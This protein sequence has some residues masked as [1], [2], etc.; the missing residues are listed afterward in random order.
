MNAQV[1]RQWSSDALTARMLLSSW[2]LPHSSISKITSVSDGISIIRP[3]PVNKSAL[4]AQV[5]PG[6]LSQFLYDEIKVAR[7]N[8]ASNIKHTW[9]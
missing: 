6:W 4:P 8:A 1:A 3:Q 9:A 2:I 7:V 5:V